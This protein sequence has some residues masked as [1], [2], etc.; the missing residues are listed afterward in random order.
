MAQDREL[1]ELAAL[2]LKHDKQQ[3]L[4]ET[5]YYALREAIITNLLPP[6]SVMNERMLAQ[7]LRVS[8]TPVRDA[9]RQLTIEGFLTGVPRQGL[10]VTDLSLKDIEEIYTMRAALEGAAARMSARTISPS[11]LVMLEDVCAQMAAAGEQGDVERLL[12]LNGRFH[13]SLCN[14]ARNRRLTEQVLRLYDA[15]RPICRT[16]FADRARVRKSLQEHEALV[17]AIRGRDPDEAERLAREHMT[18]SMLTQMKLHQTQR[19]DLVTR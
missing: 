5:V 19:L 10:I 1:A 14:A 17:A 11:E 13:E 9:L 16:V 2:R 6:G 12:V 18:Q 3:A 15:V 8:R 7:A 4:S